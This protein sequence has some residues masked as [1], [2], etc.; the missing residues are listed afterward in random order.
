MNSERETG[1]SFDLSAVGSGILCGLILMLA[2]A[3]F[4]GIYAYRSPLSPG[5]EAVWTYLWQG[6]GALMAGFQSGRRAAG[7]GW[8]HGSMAGA[9][10][11][12]TMALVMGVLTDLPTWAA[13]L[14]GLAGGGRPRGGG[15]D[16]RGQPGRPVAGLRKPTLGKAQWTEF[17][18]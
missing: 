14:K 10:L 7:A 3:L 11:A 4:Q 12:L 13:L 1:S 15:G 6:L 17:P 9:G 16:H 18:S 2:G 8:L 5:A